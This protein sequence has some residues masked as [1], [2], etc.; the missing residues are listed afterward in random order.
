MHAGKGKQ[1][2]LTLGTFLIFLVYFQTVNTNAIVALFEDTWTLGAS[3]PL[4]SR[5]IAD[6]ALL[7]VKM[8][9]EAGLDAPLV[10]GMAY[11][12]VNYQGLTPKLS[13]VENI[14]S[15]NGG[16]GPV[17]G[18]RF[19]VVLDNGQ[20]WIF[21]SSSEMSLTPSGSSLVASGVFDGSMRA[22]VVIGSVNAADLDAF[23]S[24]I[25]ISGSVS[26]SSSGDTATYT[27]S[28]EKSGTGDLLM[29]A[30]PHHLDILSSPQLTD[31]SYN[32][33]K[34]DMI[35]VVGDSWSLV[36]DLTTVDFFSPQ[37]I[38]ASKIEDIRA[39]LNEDTAFEVVSTDPYFG[40]KQ[41]AA[42]A[43]LALIADEL[44]ETALASTFIEKVKPTLQSWLEATNVDPLV[45]DQT[46]GGLVTINGLYD[47]Q[48]D[49]GQ[50]YYND[51]HFHYGYHIFTA[52]VIARVDQA[53]ADQYDEMIVTMIRDISEPSGSDP[54]FTQTR[55]V[56]GIFLIA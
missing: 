53:W 43:R 27:F 9:W 22:A 49:F 16:T 15:V 34:G 52:A 11:V 36:E 44:G 32:T 5:A 6:N 19:E 39:A 41:M 24:A 13:T 20:T 3:E 35:G 46:W 45:Y 31:I 28:W 29:M 12:T 10:Q 42:I 30:L 8:V 2:R 25:P 4:G 21:Y 50:G 33:I 1:E 23:S 54:Y 48:A 17:M 56:L 51:H 14:V 37:D 7:S 18:S 55:L 47:S 40:G 26:A 38:D